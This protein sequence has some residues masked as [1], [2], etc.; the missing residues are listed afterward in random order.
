MNNGKIRRVIFCYRDAESNPARNCAVMAIVRY[1]NG[2]K[3]F[4]HFDRGE[5]L[6]KTAVR[7]IMSGCKYHEW[8]DE[9]HNYATWES[10]KG[11]TI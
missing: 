10:I 1:K 2:N 5:T 4:I 3:R 11:A 9:T 8:T 7:F 6:P